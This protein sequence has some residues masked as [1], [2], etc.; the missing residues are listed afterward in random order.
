MAGIKQQDAQHYAYQKLARQLLA[1]RKPQGAF[2]GNF[3]IIIKEPD[4]PV[5][6]RSYQKNIK[7]RIHYRKL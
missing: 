1:C 2:K 4:Q 3:D 7:I 6:E 5:A